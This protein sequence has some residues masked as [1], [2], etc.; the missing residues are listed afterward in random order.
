MNYQTIYNHL[1]TKFKDHPK[2]KFQT[3][4]HHI[5]PQSFA[6]LD[7]IENIDGR[8]NRVHLPHREHFIAHLL[9]ARIWRDH[10]FKGSMMARAFKM[11][12][13]CRKLSS[14]DYAWLKLNYSHS[15]ETKQKISKK[16]SGSNNGMFGK[17]HAIKSKNKMSEMASNR[18]EEYRE[19]MSKAQSN[20]S[21]ETRH[22]MSKAQKGKRKSEETKRKL[23][24]KAKGRRMSEESK[25]NLSNLKKGIPQEKFIC[26]ICGKE[27]GGK[28]C[29][30][31]HIKWHERNT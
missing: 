20:R 22:K 15:E 10:K 8:W 5:I 18:S 9:L 3:N 30:T 4:D 26:H 28:G 17:K 1:I 31:L 24:E 23:S 25:N 11:M 21:D 7:G 6:K 13:D 12:S 27:I 16:T 19:K 2:V 29:L 14:K